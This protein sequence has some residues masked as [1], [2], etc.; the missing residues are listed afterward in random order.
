MTFLYVLL[1][2]GCLERIFDLKNDPFEKENLMT[3]SNCNVHFNKFDILSISTAVK[4]DVGNKYCRDVTNLKDLSTSTS[5]STSRYLLSGQNKNS[6]DEDENGNGNGNENGN[7]NLDIVRALNTV[8][9][10]FAACKHKY[11]K[12]L[13]LKI[14]Y[15]FPK[16]SAFVLYGNIPYTN[17]IA[18]S[19]LYGNAT[20]NIPIADELKGLNY[21]L[22]P[23]L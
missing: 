13:I 12:N 6:T 14:A 20:C 16:L 4:K 11:H 1:S 23:G 3:G 22:S 15:I 8:A 5:T 7:E 9:D 21:E 10:P 17:F 18:E 19:K 2:V